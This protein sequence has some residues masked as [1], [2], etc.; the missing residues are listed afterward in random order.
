QVLEVDLRAFQI[1]MLKSPHDGDVE[2]NAS[3]TTKRQ[4]EMSFTAR[5]TT[6]KRKKRPYKFTAAYFL[7][8]SVFERQIYGIY[9]CFT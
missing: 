9:P 6:S 4:F 3:L 2:H 8:L 7:S 5:R 1:V